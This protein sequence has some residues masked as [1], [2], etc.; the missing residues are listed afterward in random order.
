MS[1]WS[2]VTTIAHWVALSSGWPRRFVAFAAG[3][4]GALALAPVNLLPAM[5]VPMTVAVWL[6]DGADETSLT[7]KGPRYFWPS[8]RAAAAAGWWWGFGYFVAGFWWLGAACLVEPEKFAWALP[9]AVLGVPVILAAFPALGFAVAR[10]LWM[11]GAT[12]ILSLTFGLGM[13]EWLRGF[14]LTGFPWNDYGM[15]L[16]THLILAQFAS[17]GGLQGLNWL[18]VAICAV[19]ATLADDTSDGRRTRSSGRRLAPLAIGVAALAALAIFGGLRLAQGSAGFVP[20]VKLRIM[21]PNIAEDE[22]FTYAN[23]HKI[24]GDY[25][26]LSDRATSSTTSGL[27][28]VTHLI[29]PESAFPFILSRDGEA[30]E[31]ITGALP[32]GTAL[33]TGAARVEGQPE[34]GSP[35]RYY[36]AIQVLTRDGAILDTYDKVHLVP[37]GE[38]LPLDSI[39]RRF[40]IQHFVSIPG[41]FTAGSRHRLLYAPG[42]PAA[43]PAICYEA[44]FSDEIMQDIPEAIS[45]GVILNLTNDSWFGQTAGPYQHLSQVRLRTIEQGLPMIRAANTGISAIIDAY[46][47]TLEKT[48]LGVAAVLDG[49]LPERIKRTIFVKFHSY[50][51]GGIGAIL[52][53]L[54]LVLRFR[55]P[56]RLYSSR[57]RRTSA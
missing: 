16:G 10:A 1:G 44:I 56:A 50:L 25:L 37:F 55:R 21:Q 40:G 2:L 54:L 6:I 45:P 29:W 41:G 31:T 3:A 12:R 5:V 13:S 9:I 36:N 47:R 46:G 42:L 28:D 51:P 57:S 39:L 4:A 52:L 17:V 11:P 26:A 15:A 23:R 48:S 7:S 18:A 35:P 30:L 24:L 14:V 33:I 53:T 43:I 20:G 32:A 22:G 49:P 34:G 8:L 38:Y 19:P 27:A